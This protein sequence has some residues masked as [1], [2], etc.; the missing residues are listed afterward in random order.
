MCMNM[1]M[2]IRQLLWILPLV[3]MG[4]LYTPTVIKP[5]DLFS[6]DIKD[7]DEIAG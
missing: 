5:V 4:S 3:L 6:H 7:T 2:S 1:Y